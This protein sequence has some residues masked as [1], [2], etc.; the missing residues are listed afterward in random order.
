MNDAVTRFILK[1]VLYILYATYLNTLG[2]GN[3]SNKA[4]VHWIFSNASDLLDGTTT[5]RDIAD[6]T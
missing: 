4:D 2:L 6:G 1:A 5:L 3:P